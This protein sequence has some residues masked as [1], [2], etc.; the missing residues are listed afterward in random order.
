MAKLKTP[1]SLSWYPHYYGVFPFILLSHLLQHLLNAQLP[2]L[3]HL[4]HT[5]LLPL[6]PC[7]NSC[8][9]HAPIYLTC[10]QQVSNIAY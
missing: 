10:V 1:R 7:A 5:K 4:S 3:K 9:L 8:Q 2:F 6:A